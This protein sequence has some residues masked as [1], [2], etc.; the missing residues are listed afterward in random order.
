MP[1]VSGLLLSLSQPLDVECV[2]VRVDVCASFWWDVLCI[3]VCFSS[4][5][6]PDVIDMNSQI[7]RCLFP[8]RHALVLWCLI[9]ATDTMRTNSFFF[10]QR[11][12]S[13]RLWNHQLPNDDCICIV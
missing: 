3:I 6:L 9:R 4:Q 10:K 1:D 8:R 12:F 7:L 5:N 2:L 11:S 13:F